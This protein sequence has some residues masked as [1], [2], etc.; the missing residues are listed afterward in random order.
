MKNQ[1]DPWPEEPFAYDI[2]S[3]DGLPIGQS[4]YPTVEHALQAAMNF[5][6]RYAHQGYYKDCRMEQIPLH[7]LSQ[8]MYL[9][10]YPLPMSPAEAFRRHQEAGGSCTSVYEFV[11]S[12][13]YEAFMNPEEEE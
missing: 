5:V 8:R 12:E 7:E 2:I 6:L 4:R 11:E 1:F 3:P 10:R 9:K 13:E